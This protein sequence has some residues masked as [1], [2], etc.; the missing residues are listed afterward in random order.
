MTVDEALAIVATKAAGRTRWEGSEA[1]V[2]EV[3]AA[4]VRRLRDENA[5]LS[6]PDLFWSADDIECSRPSIADIA[7]DFAIGHVFE[8]DRGVTL[9]R[10]F[11]VRAWEEGDRP[12]VHEFDTEEAAVSFSRGLGEEG[13]IPE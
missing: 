9:P 7:N 13:E 5:R 11:C 2:D 12:I 6:I 8:V 3:L 4:E 1:W 10:V